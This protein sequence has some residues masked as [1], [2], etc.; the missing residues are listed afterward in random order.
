MSLFKVSRA[1]ISF[2]Y[3]YAAQEVHCRIG[4]EAL[5]DRG[6]SHPEND[7]DLCALFEKYQQSIF[8]A[9]AQKIANNDLESDGT[10]CVRNLDLKR[11]R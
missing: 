2:K 8:R 9:V 5:V 4:R 7:S 11:Q 3:E 1:G 10:V 6:G